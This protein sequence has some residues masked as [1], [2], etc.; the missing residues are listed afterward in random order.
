M[1]ER[2]GA[3][4]LPR[5]REIPDVGLYLDQTVKYI[6]RSLAPLGCAEMTTSMV[7]NYVKQGYVRNPVKKQYDADQIARLLII[8]LIKNVLP[9]EHIGKLFQWQEAH[10]T[11]ETGYDLFCAEMDA[12]IRHLWRGAVLSVHG[13]GEDLSLLRSVVAAC[14]N[15]LYLNSRFDRL[16]ITP[17]EAEAKP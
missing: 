12:Q 11:L 8:A 16:N 7:S 9:M 1:S 17:A 5:Y 13:K 3:F 10:F 2:L 4:R 14:A 15:V 6:N